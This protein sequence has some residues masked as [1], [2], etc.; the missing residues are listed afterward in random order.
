MIIHESNFVVEG[1]A[2]LH[3]KH[4]FGCPTRCYKTINARQRSSLYH[5]AQSKHTPSQMVV[6]TNVDSMSA[7]FH[8]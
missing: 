8:F 7:D 3:F 6:L 2:T 4:G 1:G 5:Q